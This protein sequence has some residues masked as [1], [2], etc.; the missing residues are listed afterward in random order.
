[1]IPIEYLAILSYAIA[2]CFMMSLTTGLAVVTFLRRSYLD[3]QQVK[4]ASQPKTIHQ[5]VQQVPTALDNTRT[6]HG[7]QQFDTIRETTTITQVPTQTSA[8]PVRYQQTLLYN[9][10]TYNPCNDLETQPEK[11]PRQPAIT[12]SS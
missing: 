8:V 1:M 12:R 5:I 10:D 6:W 3:K 9:D 4:V 11:P 7:K 2:I